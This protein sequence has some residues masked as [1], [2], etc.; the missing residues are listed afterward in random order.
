M[1]GAAWSIP[2]VAMAISTPLAAASVGDPTLTFALPAYSA[3]ACTLLSDVVVTK[4]GSNGSPASGEPVTVTL[5]NGYT[6]ADGTTTF[7]GTTGLDGTVTLP[8]IRVPATGGNAT[9]TATSAG[10]TATTA[11]QAPVVEGEYSYILNGTVHPA[12]GIPEGSTPLYGAW[13]LAP[14]GNIIDGLTGVAVGADVD[15]IGQ[16]FQTDA[17]WYLPVKLRN[18]TFGYYLNG[19]WS[20]APAVPAG[21]AA[22]YGGWFLTSDGFL[23]DQDGV[24]VGADVDLVGQ[25]FQT[26][27]GWWLPLRLTNGTF[28]YYLNGVWHPT[29]AVP[30]GSTPVYGG[31]FLTNDNRLVDQ[32]G[33]VVGTNIATVGDGFQT[34]AGW[35]LPAQL[36]NGV[37]GYYLN[38]VWYFTDGVP[39]GST[40][41]YG[42]WFLT[43][44]NTIVEGTGG[45]IVA[46]NTESIGQGFETDLGFYVPFKGQPTA[47]TW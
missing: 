23:V 45:R 37:N 8:G 33:A 36:T 16:G 25:G 39:A 17:G 27:A 6:F 21:S 15:S 10:L 14:N 13:F 46:Y 20:P 41:L 1:T 30:A 35:Y 28:G 32:D 38:G 43:P 2:V 4:T 29:P 34:D 47:C 40:P 19:V 26:D 12:V 11:V 7:T 22:L 18:G 5:E 24:Y 44:D 31:Y 3:T 9:P 42:G